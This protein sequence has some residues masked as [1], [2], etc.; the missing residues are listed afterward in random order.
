MKLLATAI[1]FVLIN[2][3]ADQNQIS[4]YAF[5][6]NLPLKKTPIIDSTDLDNF[7]FKN[8]LSKNQMDL[9]N[10][11]QIY[12]PNSS[13]FI[14]ASANYKLKLS[15][16]FTSIV[17]TYSPVEVMLI[18]V[19]ANYDSE[20]KLIDYKMIA[21]DEN[22]DNWSRV[23]SEIKENK[24]YVSSIDYSTGEPIKTSKIF[25]ISHDGKI[26]ANH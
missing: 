14:T 20:F 16:K 21:L 6:N 18:T 11:N 12:V 19:L 5:L 1:I 24:I 7:E 25:Y 9:L 8:K 22:F 3:F 2:I 13:D 10:I 17:I 26:I 15:D 4:K 23:T